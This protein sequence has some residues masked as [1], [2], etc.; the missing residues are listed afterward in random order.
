VKQARAELR[1]ARCAECAAQVTRALSSE[2]S[3][4][5]V[6]VVCFECRG[7]EPT[8]W[9]AGD[10]FVVKAAGGAVFEDA[11]LSEDWTEYDEKLADSCSIM[12]LQHR[13]EVHREK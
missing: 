8:R 4:A 5:W 2:D 13:F 9:T 12:E 3:G 6:P 1:A 10:G 11:D 7:C